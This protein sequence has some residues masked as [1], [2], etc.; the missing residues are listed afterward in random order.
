MANALNIRTD[1]RSIGL[2][3]ALSGDITEDSDFSLILTQNPP[4]L[5]LDLADV[6][7]INSTGVREWINFVNALS[8][9]GCRLE[10]DRCSV[11]I[12]QQMNM[13]ANFRGKGTVRS[14]Y[15]PY[16]CGNCDSEATILVD[17]SKADVPD[18]KSPRPCPNCQQPME[19]DDLPDSYL[20]FRDHGE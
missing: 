1:N 7:R 13:I 4:M 9:L 5:T 10:L 15:A 2:W 14:I 3:A 6:K 11:A 12:V 19:F 20:S 17:F 8:K 18:F 16:F